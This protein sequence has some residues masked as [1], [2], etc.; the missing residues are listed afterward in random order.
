MGNRPTWP[1]SSSAPRTP[2]N[3]DPVELVTRSTE[4]AMRWDAHDIDYYRRGRQRFHHA[5]V[6]DLGLDYDALQ[7]WF[8]T[9]LSDRGDH[10]GRA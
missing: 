8:E 9:Q 1:A 2:G 4:F 10:H 3:T 5:A 7:D 6:G